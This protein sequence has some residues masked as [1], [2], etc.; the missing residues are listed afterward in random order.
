MTVIAADDGPA[1]GWTEAFAWLQ[2]RAGQ[3]G[4]PLCAAVVLVP[5]AQLMAQARRHWQRHCPQGFAPRFE[6]TRNWA[7]QFAASAPHA[8]EYTGERA[9]DSITA[10]ALLERA[11]LGDQR[12]VLAGPLLEL[13]AQL[14][15]AAAA[16]PPGRRAAWGD[17]A[18]TLLPTAGDGGAL[19]LEA[20]AAQLALEWVLASRHASD[21]LFDAPAR[22]CAR[23]LLVIE[24]LQPDPLAQALR[25]H[26]GD[27]GGALQLRPAAELPPACIA[28]HPA[29]DA[30]AEARRAA[31]CVLAHL[32]QGRAPVALAAMDRALTRRV[33]ALL[34]GAGVPLRDETGWT[35]STTRAAARVLALLRACAWDAG[36]DTVLDWLK[37][38]PAADALALRALERWLRRRGTP[39]WSAAAH[40]LA[41]QA[42]RHPAEAA[43]VAQCERWRG[44][45]RAARPLRDWLAALREALQASGAWDALAQDAAG[46][47]V[48][49]ELRLPAGL[50]AGLH[51]A[52]GAG[53]R[54]ALAEFT[55][56]VSEV[57]ECARHRPEYPE[58]AP[59]VVLPLAQLLARPF[60]ALVLPGCD[61]KRL[62]VAPE[63]PGPWSA[64][65]RE[66]LGLPTREDLAQA[67]RAAWQQALATAHVDV[68]WRTGEGG[69][70]L[71]ASA[72]VQA[73]QLDGV[74]A[75]GRDACA[76]RRV[77]P[78]PVARP[79]ADGSA[80]PVA[81]LSASAYEDLRQC[82]YRFFALRQLGLRGDDELDGG[83]D[84]RDFGTWLHAVLQHFHEALATDAQ[85]ARPALMDAAAERALCALR[86]S[87]ADFLPYTSGWPQLRDGY[88]QWL[89]QHEAKEG[90]SF[91]QAELRATQPLA[92]VSLVGTLDR[93]DVI[94]PAGGGAPLHLVIDYKSESGTRTAARVK[95]GGEDT[96]LAFYAAL[97]PPGSALRAAYVNV[98]E[99]GETKFHEQPDVAALRDALVA[100]IQ[101]DLERIAAGA[102]IT[103]LGEG[104][105]CEWCDARG[106]C[107]RDFWQDQA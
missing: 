35:L 102:P 100:G 17:M 12:E 15:A 19:R 39:H 50:D 38:S 71:L 6:T 88:L 13:A 82:P 48:L 63:P 67:Q 95:A 58:G 44:A 24:G 66:G 30:E 8:T 62:P 65:Q 56:W 29:E 57:L 59:V 83:V 94:R 93:V 81:Q 49:A 77:A 84:K 14:A 3:L 106:L 1:R 16:V 43:L 51:D 20:A 80:L 105:A 40:Y 85:A 89:A 76:P 4:V 68:L 27:D 107:R 73:L 78:A 72:L 7:G 21:A 96:Q 5:Y 41:E 99:R 26:W 79:C 91:G 98:G 2:A 28:L 34:Q 33:C 64:A 45:L 23:L 90:A 25:E 55:H 37:H 31:A 60:D 87:E 54:L 75:A 32:A 92:G 46:A 52:D 22:S 11:G 86:L 9:R 70:P 18:R 101:R 42:Q 97:M 53:R 103:A 69:E 61:E 10:R 74:A 36:S 47:R 104:A